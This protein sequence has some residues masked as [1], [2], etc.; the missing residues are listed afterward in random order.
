MAQNRLRH[1]QLNACEKEKLPCFLYLIQIFTKEK[2][3]PTNFLEYNQIDDADKALVSALSWTR[4]LQLAKKCAE[5]TNKKGATEH[6]EVRIDVTT[7]SKDERKLYH[8]RFHHMFS[9][10]L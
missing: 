10:I 6:G 7:K 8:V 2:E 1:T 9:R 5:A 3:V 4:L